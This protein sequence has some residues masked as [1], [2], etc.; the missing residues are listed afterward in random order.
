MEKRFT[1]PCKRIAAFDLDHTLLKPVS[2]AKFARGKNDATLVF[3]EI[4]DKLNELMK[5]GY[6]IVIFS[7]Q[8]AL[9]GLIQLSDI[10]HK[11]DTFLPKGCEY[12]VYVASKS[13][14]YRKPH[15]GMLDAFMDDNGAV[16]DIF[17]VGDAAGR[18]GDFSDS[19]RKFAHNCGIQFYTPEEF[20]LGAKFNLPPL[21]IVNKP[22]PMLPNIE[23]PERTV[24]VMVG[25]PGC[26]KSTLSGE[27]SEKY[28]GT[29]VLSNDVLGNATKTLSQLKK[30]LKSGVSRIIIDNTNGKRSVRAK[31]TKAVRDA[32][33]LVSMII[34]N[35]DRVVS[36]YM[37]HYRAHKELKEIIPNVAYNVY[38]KNF[39][40]VDVK[41][42]FDK[43]WYYTP[44]YPQE[45]F[46]LHF[47]ECRSKS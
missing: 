18:K 25:P 7:N 6:K 22:V 21:P 45:A 32:G 44:D 19:D 27:L 20:F 34:F 1:K 37:N 8:K 33:Y 23:I 10:Y 11:I 40:T 47:K 39:E 43:I 42:D 13:D 35:V 9:G 3:P 30:D 31:I 12:D 41:D 17:Y 28:P 14:T 36:E 5:D 2:G 46:K 16:T 38:Y 29:V 15:T 26:G 4:K 24:V